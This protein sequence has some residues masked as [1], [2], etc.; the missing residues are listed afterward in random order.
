MNV[1]A[2]FDRGV[3]VTCA[4]LARRRGVS[5]PAITKRV[6]QLEVEGKIH[7]RREG[8]SRLVDLAAFDRA[9]GEVGDAVKEQ[10]AESSRRKVSPM[11]RDAQAERAQY[12]ARLSEARTAMQLQKNVNG[13]GRAGAVPAVILVGPR[14]QTV[15]EQIVA[16]LTSSKISDVNPFA[17]KL[18]V[19]V[20]TRYEG[21][22]WWLFADPATRPALMHGY[23]DGLDGPQI[24]AKEGW[25]V[26]GIEFRC[27]LDF[28]CGVYDW[29]AAYF[30]P[31]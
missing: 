20:E 11:M 31:G 2:E 22:G 23:L 25:N 4:E 21:D 3:W 18:R 24:D 8:K 16:S 26:P 12:E 6:D 14:L 13:T 29:R 1:G 28:G 15:A 27:Q 10:A 30:N 7:S 9:V 5:R 19:E 17:G